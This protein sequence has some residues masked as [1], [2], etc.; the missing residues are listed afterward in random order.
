MLK[1]T[2]LS[3]EIAG[4]MYRVQGQVAFSITFHL[5]FFLFLRGCL[6]NMGL[7]NDQAGWPEDFRKS[8]CLC[9]PSADEIPGTGCQA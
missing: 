4:S 6:L 1:W 7:T 8:S 5:I 2:G 9:L 3:F